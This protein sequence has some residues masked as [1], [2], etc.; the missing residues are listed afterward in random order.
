LTV[1]GM[2]CGAEGGAEYDGSQNIGVY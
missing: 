2:V 1:K